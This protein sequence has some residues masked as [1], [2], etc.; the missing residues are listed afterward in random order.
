[1]SFMYGN[2][3]RFSGNPCDKCAHFGGYVG[4]DHIRAAWCLD[5][6]IVLAQPQHG[7]AYWKPQPPGWTPPPKPSNPPTGG[8]G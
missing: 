5:G 4:P 6:R 3:D 7:C 8:A 1:M 2:R